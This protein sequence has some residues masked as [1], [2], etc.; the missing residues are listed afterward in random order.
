MFSKEAPRSR[1]SVGCLKL[2]FAGSLVD[3]FQNCLSDSCCRCIRE[4]KWHLFNVLFRGFRKVSFQ[5][6]LISVNIAATALH[7]KYSVKLRSLFDGWSLS[8]GTSFEYFA[9][10]V[11]TKKFHCFSKSVWDGVDTPE[12]WYT[13]RVDI[14][15]NLTNHWLLLFC[16]GPLHRSA[17]LTKRFADELMS[18]S[19]LDVC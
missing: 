3:T 4:K 19:C 12:S 11:T 5:F 14:P 17:M 9:F 16:W 15:A 7:A 10:T 6:C 18:R 8:S 2:H 1:H 13:Q